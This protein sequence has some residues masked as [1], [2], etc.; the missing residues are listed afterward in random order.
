MQLIQIN[1]AKQ[2]VGRVSNDIV[3]GA[4]DLWFDFRT[5]KSDTLL[6]NYD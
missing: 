2:Q 5:V 4:G 3:I 6:P 1:K